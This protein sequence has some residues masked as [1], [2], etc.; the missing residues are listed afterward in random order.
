[1]EQTWSKR[2]VLDGNSKAPPTES[3]VKVIAK[4]RNQLAQK[5]V[6]TSYIKEPAS[7]SMAHYAINSLIR[8][9]KR[10]GIKP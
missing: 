4:M 6:D 1:M 2:I 3:Q 5:S 10:H 9:C 8:L 7:N